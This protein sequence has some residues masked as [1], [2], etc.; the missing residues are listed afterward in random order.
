MQVL[1]L[2]TMPALVGQRFTKLFGFS[3]DQRKKTTVD[4]LRVL[5]MLGSA[6]FAI[7]F[8]KSYALI[9]LNMQW[10]VNNISGKRFFPSFILSLSWFDTTVALKPFDWISKLI[11]PI[12]LTEVAL[13]FVSF[14]KLSAS[15]WDIFVTRWMNV[16]LRDIVFRTGDSTLMRQTACNNV[17]TYVTWKWSTYLCPSKCLRIY[18]VH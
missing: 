11:V 2:I 7:N 17:R 1:M 5:S 14:D 18:R 6:I 9:N 8:S 3:W 15:N 10:G 16:R 4:D 12:A 13:Q